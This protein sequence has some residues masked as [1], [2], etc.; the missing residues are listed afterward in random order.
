M[1]Y[2]RNKVSARSFGSVSR[3]SVHVENESSQYVSKC[4]VVIQSGKLERTV[5][6]DIRNGSSCLDARVRRES[7]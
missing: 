6:D 1:N 2:D 5:S 4:H 7:Q 3:L